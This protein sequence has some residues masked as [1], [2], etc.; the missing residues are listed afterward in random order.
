MLAWALFNSFFSHKPRG[1]PLGI[2][3]KNILSVSWEILKNNSGSS[4]YQVT[5]LECGVPQICGHL[6]QEWGTYS[7]PHFM[8]NDE[9]FEG[10]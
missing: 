1:Y 5:P 2:M 8:Y 9:S 4:S 6:F 10:S 3:W 7:T